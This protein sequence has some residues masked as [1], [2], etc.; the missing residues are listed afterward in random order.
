M[1]KKKYPYFRYTGWLVG[2]PGRLK[3]WVNYFEGRGIPVAIMRNKKGSH[4]L[5]RMGKEVVE[6]EYDLVNGKIAMVS[7]G[8]GGNEEKILKTYVLV[9][10]TLQNQ[11]PACIPAPVPKIE[12]FTPSEI[13]KIDSENN[14]PCLKWLV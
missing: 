4:S 8:K 10:E 3:Y 9:Y 11:V 1:K 14:V 13:K 6:Q 12:G 2:T 7:E 5:W